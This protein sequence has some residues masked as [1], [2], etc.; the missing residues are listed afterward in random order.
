MPGRLGLA[1]RTPPRE[2]TMIFMTIYTFR[3]EQ[4]KQAVARF[5]ETGGA[6]PPGVKILARWHDVG[7]CR[8]Y[9]IEE[10]DDATAISAF[11]YR[12]NDLMTLET[13][14]VIND[15]Q[16]GKVLTS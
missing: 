8:G 12:W 16:L 2:G 1:G 7:G 10:S 13:F 11:G 3:P 15:E 6:P 5:L 14:P 9:T 4:R